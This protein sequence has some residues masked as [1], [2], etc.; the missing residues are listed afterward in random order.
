MELYR[1]LHTMGKVPV[2]LVLYPGEGHGN[3]KAAARY[4]LSARLMRWMDHYLK[5]P[6]GDPPPHELPL[7]REKLGLS[8]DGEGDETDG[9]KA[10]PAQ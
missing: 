5:G 2:R 4:D 3:R 10:T 6:G 9:D 7:D 1:Y 8:E